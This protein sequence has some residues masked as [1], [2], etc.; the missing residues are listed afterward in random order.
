M[1]DMC[2]Y[3]GN[4]HECPEVLDL[5]MD[6]DIPLPY[7][8]GQY[9]QRCV[10]SGLV[11]ATENKLYLSDAI[12][13]FALKWQDGAWRVNENITSFNAR[14]L[15]RPIWRKALQWQRGVVFA[16]ELGETKSGVHYLMKA[17]KG[18]ALAALYK[19]WTGPDGKIVRS[20]AVI[21]QDAH[22]RFANF[23]DKST[24][25]FLPMKG[26]FLRHWLD[27]QIASSPDIEALLSKPILHS[28]LNV[29]PVKTFRH[30]Q[31]LGDTQ[32]LAAD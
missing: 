16:S 2:G 7:P 1:I 8:R 21:T 26:P 29:T 3:F 9:Y 27:P 23:H 5:L 17:P 14:N 22:P 4:L 6:L 18:M 31:S 10:V 32:Y 15:T 19:D 12:W 24:P 28:D 20:M 30:A 11:T 25:C 13:W